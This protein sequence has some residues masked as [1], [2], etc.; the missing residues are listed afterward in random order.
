MGYTLQ[1]QEI[2]FDQ[3][4]FDTWVE[5][6]TGDGTSPVYW[7]CFGEIYSYPDGEL[8]GR[9]VGVDVAHSKRISKDSVLQLNRKIFLYTDKDTGEVLKEN[10]GK[11][12]RHIQY[13]Y[14]LI[15]YKLVGDR[16]R[17]YVTQGSG[18]R[19]NKIG[20]GYGIKARN[21]G[22]AIT[23]SAPVFL[24]F[25]TPRGR[26][27]AY[28]NYEFLLQPGEKDPK[29]K[30][31]LTWVRYGD[32][33]PF[34]KENSKGVIQLVSHRL[35]NFESIPEPLRSYIEKEASLWMKPPQDLAEIKSLQA[36]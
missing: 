26:Y 18:N 33:A 30:F 27:Q 1:A 6:R 20:P 5:L 36:Q 31:Q 14:Q 32:L 22:D 7:Y 25:P 2:K 15:S 16:M 9:M 10:N 17:T 11:P 34:F 24:D 28:E 12:V 35:E 21:L 8:V 13:P 23:F 4:L 29:N 19:I 3:E